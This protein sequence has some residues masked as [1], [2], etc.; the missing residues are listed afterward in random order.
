MSPLALE[1]ETQR[2]RQ[3][4]SLLSRA[5]ILGDEEAKALLEEHS[6]VCLSIVAHY[7]GKP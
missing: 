6:E 3:I 2:K 4:E 7:Q 1:R 5:D